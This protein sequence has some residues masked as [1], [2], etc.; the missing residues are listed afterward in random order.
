MI[1]AIYV[2]QFSGNCI[3]IPS[4][5]KLT[6]QI[7]FFTNPLLI[8]YTP[9]EATDSSPAG[10]FS[11]FALS[12]A[13]YMSADWRDKKMYSRTAFTRVNDRKQDGEY[14]IIPGRECPAVRRLRYARDSSGKTAGCIR[15]G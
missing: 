7:V 8:I 5:K 11:L 1:L 3:I 4:V 14:Y 9:L 13:I 15:A 10:R 2:L 6:L 12:S